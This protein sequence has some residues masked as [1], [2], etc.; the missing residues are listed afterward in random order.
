MSVKWLQIHVFLFF[1]NSLHSML[2][3]HCIVLIKAFLSRWCSGSHTTWQA[4][5][6]LLIKESY[7]LQVQNL[8]LSLG[9][10]GGC[11]KLSGSRWQTFLYIYYQY[12]LIVYKLLLNIPYGV[13]KGKSSLMLWW[14]AEAELDLTTS[15][16]LDELLLNLHKCK[17]SMAVLETAFARWYI[18]PVKL[19]M[20]YPSVSNTCFRGCPDHGT[21]EL[22]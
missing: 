11:Q 2:T 3:L 21:L 22:H 18:T 6:L 13:F 1:F 17:F 5:L 20:I 4:F 14:E 15:D 12:P 9:G 8:F 19:H 7:K 16:W 10:G